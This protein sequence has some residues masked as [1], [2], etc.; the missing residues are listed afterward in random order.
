MPDDGHLLLGTDR[1]EILDRLGAGGMGV[2]FRARDR[3]LGEEIALKTLSHLDPQAIYRFKREFR[4]VSELHHPGLVR[5]KELHATQTAWFFTMDLVEGRDLSFRTRGTATQPEWTEPLTLGSTETTLPI[6]GFDQ[7]P[8]EPDTAVFGTRQPDPTWAPR[9]RGLFKRLAELLVALHEAGIVH[10]DLKP[11]NVR[12]RPDDRVV[13]L[14]FG[15]ATHLDEESLG[16]STTGL[17]AGTVPYLAPEQTVGEKITPAADWYAFGTILYEALT[18]RLPHEGPIF[19]QILHKQTRRPPNVRSLVPE[20]PPD[21]AD[22]AMLLL[23]PAPARRPT[24]AMLTDVLSLRPVPARWSRQVEPA[25]KPPRSAEI[26]QALTRPED[27]LRIVFFSGEAPGPTA[28]LAHCA[29]GLRARQGTVLSGRC[30]QSESVS[31]QGVDDLVDHLGR[32]L[33]ATWRHPDG[34]EPTPSM[35]CLARTFP[36]LRR[37]PWLRRAAERAD[38]DRSI[39]TLAEGFVQLMLS[40]PGDGPWVLALDSLEAIDADGLSLLCATA[41]GLPPE[42]SWI[43]AAAQNPEPGRWLSQRLPH[44]RWMSERTD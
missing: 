43:L 9:L 42:R 6:G 38:E 29:E 2:V 20:A 14:D 31:F 26:R 25:P 16:A 36:S 35:G 23:D 37:I 13:L 32:K 4:R 44:A 12:V 10:R 3:V 22:L 34:R 27:R 8:T 30:R 24:A 40:I 17:L 19:Q 28:R 21:L 1:F 11:S 39:E 33:K 5:L 15:L 7:D 18:G 41:D